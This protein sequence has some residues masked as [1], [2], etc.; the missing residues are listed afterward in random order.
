[1]FFSLSSSTG[2]LYLSDVR[3]DQLGAHRFA[4]AR[5]AADNHALFLE[6]DQHIAEHI[7]GNGEDV[8]CIVHWRL[9]ELD[10]DHSSR[11]DA[12]RSSVAVHGM[13]AAVIHVSVRIDGDEHRPN[14]CLERRTR[15]CSRVG[16]DGSVT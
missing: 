3:H 10:F 11:R 8:R 15:A 13:F 12:Y 16:C 5:F 4:S 14:V 9:H 7:L 2:A 1:M 6:I